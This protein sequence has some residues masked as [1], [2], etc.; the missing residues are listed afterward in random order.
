MMMDACQ[1]KLKLNFMPLCRQHFVSLTTGEGLSNSHDF[2]IK[3][4][5]SVEFSLQTPLKVYECIV[6]VR[7]CL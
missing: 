3:I 6:A 2:D 5:F 1:E 4:V 7:I